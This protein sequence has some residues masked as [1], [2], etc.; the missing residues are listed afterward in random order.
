[1]ANDLV[2]RN[3]LLEAYDKAH[4]GPPGGARKL[5]EDAPSELTEK[6]IL[7]LKAVAYGC[8]KNR[9]LDGALFISNIHATN[10]ETIS[11]FEALSIVYEL[12]DKLE[13]ENQNVNMT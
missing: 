10:Q 5:I 4:V 7:A 2:L 3:K 6:H 1:M 8:N 12:I 13:N 9:K 11:F